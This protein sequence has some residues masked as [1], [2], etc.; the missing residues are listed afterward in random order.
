M[1]K[2]NCLSFDA[3]KTCLEFKKKKFYK[4]IFHQI[5]VD[6]IYMS[7]F[8]ISFASSENCYVLNDKLLYDSNRIMK[9]YF[10]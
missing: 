2:E 9:F 5:D 4:D 6:D 3:F 10:S 8:L 1:V 7:N